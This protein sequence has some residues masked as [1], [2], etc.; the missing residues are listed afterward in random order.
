MLYEPPP[1][2]ADHAEQFAHDWADKFE[3]YCAV[4]MEELGV[5][6]DK[7]GEQDYERDGRWRAFNCYGR[8][9]GSN[10]TGIVV[11][12]GAL[13]PDLLNGKKGGRIWPKL[14]LRHRIDSIIAHEY[15][16]ICLGS[17]VSALQAASRTELPIGHEARRLCRAMAR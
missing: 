12:S 5:P 2:P 11:D 16:E 10:I 1:D 3:E 13:N 6:N 17:H 7:I 9:G 14:P 8:K 15:E 4:R